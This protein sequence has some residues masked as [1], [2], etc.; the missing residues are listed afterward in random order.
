MQ[1]P[2]SNGYWPY[3]YRMDRRLRP[4][5]S[6]LVASTLEEGKHFLHPRFRSLCR[7]TR[8]Q[9]EIHGINAICIGSRGVRVRLRM[10]GLFAIAQISTYS[11][12]SLNEDGMRR[13]PNGGGFTHF[14][15]CCLVPFVHCWL[16]GQLGL[17]RGRN[18]VRRKRSQI[19]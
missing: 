19:G 15:G 6:I 10:E 2:I 11:L 8:T 5:A 9:R 3:T 16:S 14:P 18:G 1:D 4:S 12:A 13:M 7:N 17:V